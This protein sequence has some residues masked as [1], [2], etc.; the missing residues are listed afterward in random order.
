MFNDN[1]TKLMFSVNYL[2]DEEALTAEF[3]IRLGLMRVCIAIRSHTTFIF[4]VIIHAT[5]CSVYWHAI[6]VEVTYNYM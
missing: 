2:Q 1:T 6:Y 4:E 5:T 3:R